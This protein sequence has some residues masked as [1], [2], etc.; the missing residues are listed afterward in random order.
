M[1]PIMKMYALAATVIALQLMVLAGIVGTIRGRKKTFVNP[2]DAKQLKG[3]KADLDHPD[4]RR[5]QRAHM[6]AMESA[7]PFFVIGA[8][9]VATGATKD[10]AM[11]YFGVFVAVRILHSI[12][13]LLGKQPFRTISF[14]I[15][16]LALTGMAIHVLRH[17]V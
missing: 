15:G 16:A 11:I 13:Y 14:A 4:V 2:E 8:L 6:N 17:V 1:D 12:F 9:Y 3:E 5:A 7:V 10:G